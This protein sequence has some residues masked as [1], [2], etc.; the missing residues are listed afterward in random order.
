MKQNI[1][2]HTSIIAVKLEYSDWFGGNTTNHVPSFF[3]FILD[4]IVTSTKYA[5]LIL[6][7]MEHLPKMKS[8]FKVWPRKF[9]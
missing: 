6:K 7:N 3:V 8:R 1:V 2:I 9:V 4:N 5:T